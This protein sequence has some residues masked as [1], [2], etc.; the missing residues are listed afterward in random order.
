MV[1]GATGVGIR[2]GVTDLG[3]GVGA[4]LAVCVDTE[5]VGSAGIGVGVTGGFSG[6]PESHWLRSIVVYWV[7]PR[8]YPSLSVM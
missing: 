2:E 5:G 7:G 3:D 1:C 4:R 8:G 6:V